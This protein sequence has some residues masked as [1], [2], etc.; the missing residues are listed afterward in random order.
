[1]FDLRE[2]AQPFEDESSELG[3]KSFEKCILSKEFNSAN[4]TTKTVRRRT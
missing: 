3:G 2:F 1:M 4:Y